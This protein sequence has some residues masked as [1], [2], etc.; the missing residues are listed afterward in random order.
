MWK[1][2]WLPRVMSTTR[3]LVLSSQAFSPFRTTSI[4][5]LPRYWYGTNTA[6]ER[7]WVDYDS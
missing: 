1:I 4:K 2:L 6:G 3:V 7:A 5:G